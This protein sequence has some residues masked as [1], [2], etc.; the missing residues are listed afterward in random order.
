MKKNLCH[1]RIACLAGNLRRG[2]NIVF[3]LF[4]IFSIFMGGFVFA[5]KERHGGFEFQ[6]SRKLLEIASLELG[7]EILQS[8]NVIFPNFP[9]GWTREKFAGVIENVRFEYERESQGIN[10]N[11]QREKRMFDYGVDENGEAYISALKPYFSYYTHVPVDT[12][13]PWVQDII[14]DIKIKLFHEISQLVWDYPN[15]EADLY[16]R[17]YVSK[18]DLNHTRERQKVLNLLLSLFREEFRTAQAPSLGKLKLGQLWSCL[19]F[20]VIENYPLAE[21]EKKYLFDEAGGLIFDFSSQPPKNFDEFIPNNAL[22][23]SHIQ[24]SM[25]E[26]TQYR[27]YIRMTENRSI[28]VE[29]TKKN[30]KPQHDTLEHFPSLIDSTES[31]IGYFMCSIPQEGE[32]R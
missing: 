9:Q 29:V 16:A 31:V 20:D 5:D 15:L 10:E 12:M 18:L 8:Q 26:K 19:Y 24:N 17:A 11:D 3:S 14:R 1:P 27:E 6:N 30:L 2:S 28:I 32:H 4:L 13:F 23:T 22:V 25:T 7:E 21:G